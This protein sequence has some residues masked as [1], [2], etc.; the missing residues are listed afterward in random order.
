MIKRA[1]L[2]QLLNRILEPRR[3]IQVM[4]GP[5]QVG[6]TT[7]VMQ[8]MKQLSFGSMLV[9]ADDVPVANRLWI[10]NAWD[11]ARRKMDMSK[12]KEFLL[13][14]DEIQKVDNWAETVKKEWD[15]DTREKRKLKVIILGSSRLLIQQG[16]TESLA[17]RFETTYITHWTY[18]EMKKAFRWSLNQYIWFG[19]YPGSAALIADEVRWKSYVKNALIETSI[20]KD[21][22]MLT[23]IEKPALLKRLF[24]IGC[25]YSSQIVSL[26]KLQSDLQEK[27]NLTTLSNYLSSLESS[28]LL[29]G[30]EK[31]SGN[32]LR[33][34]SS[35]PKF[36]VYN[37]ALISTQSNKSFK[38]ITTHPKEWGR[39]VESAV[40]AH[41]INASIV[42][43]F[44][45]YYW[46]ESSHEVDFVLEKNGKLVALEVKSGKET[47]NEGIYR[48]NEVYHPDH[49]FIIGNG[50]IPI[51][52]FLLSSPSQLF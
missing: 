33:K 21:I 38:T 51:E 11:E 3:F 34:R 5:R 9:A 12:Q 2:Q 15:T 43:N 6:K 22:L 31:F 26:N 23:R 25:V 30:L 32:A 24:E 35:K 8:L 36:Q 17:G 39:W 41:L 4:Y 16:L 50:G 10:K 44:N 19:G 47:S 40:G 7:L 14:I 27:G 37:N 29:G 48:F 42:E 49:T 52:E 1:I 28:G 46:N 45:L 13:V 18:A 20:S